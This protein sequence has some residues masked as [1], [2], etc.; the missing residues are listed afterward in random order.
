MKKKVAPRFESV[1][2]G[3]LDDGA[4]RHADDVPLRPL[5]KCRCR[6]PK[7]HPDCTLC[8]K[9]ILKDEPVRCD[10]IGIVHNKCY[11]EFEQGQAQMRDASINH[12]G[13]IG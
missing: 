5:R 4:P 1:T 2:D 8:G 3:N 6:E 7:Q 9:G 13:P 12:E 11:K 10:M